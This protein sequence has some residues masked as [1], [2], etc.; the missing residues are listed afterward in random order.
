MVDPGRGLDPEPAAAEP[1]PQA[2]V[3]VLVVEEEALGHAAEAHVEL[4][5]EHQAGAGDEPG[6]L[7]GERLARRQLAELHPR[8]AGPADPGEVEDAAA[9]VD[10]APGR[11]RDQRLPRRPP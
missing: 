9:G 10:L 3:D 11:R 7:E 8:P 4:A 6:L 2:E 5:G 1:H